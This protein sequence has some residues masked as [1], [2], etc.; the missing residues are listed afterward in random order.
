MLNQQDYFDKHLLRLDKEL[1]QLTRKLWIPVQLQKPIQQ[2]WRRVHVLAPRAD[3]RA[4][5]EVLI[6]LREV[7]GTVQYR[8]SPEFRNK[9]GRGKRRRFVEIEQPLRELTQGEWNRQQ[10]P[11]EWKRY[12]RLE[13]KCHFRAWRDVLV[14][15]NPH[16]FELKVEPCWVTVIHDKDPVVER[17]IAQI[18]RWLTRHDAGHRMEWLKGDSSCRPI[19][20]RQKEFAK[21]ARR[22]MR[23]IVSFPSE[24]DLGVSAWRIQISLRGRNHGNGNKHRCRRWA[25]AWTVWHPPFHCM[26]DI[27]NQPTVLVL[28][29]NWQ[30]IHVKTPA[31]AFCM[32]A[33][34]SALGLDVQG[35]DCILPVSW[36]A[37]LKLPV[38]SYDQVV[39]T[40]RG[41]VRMP[42]VITATAFAK[43]PLCRPRFGRRGIWERDGG[44][45]QYT[46]R[47]LARNEGN[48]DHVIPRSRGGGSTWE[49]C[50]LSHKE[51][52]SR[53]SDRLPQEAGLK[54]RRQPVAPRAYP[55]GVMIRNELKV[56]D[57]EYF[58]QKAG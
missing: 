14:F 56:R 9:R 49:N 29:R 55:A 11:E 54:L 26:K 32:M 19:P 7:I 46:G 18:K 30:A 48:I 42:T 6:A 34:G 44:I 50:V 43:V 53:K 36:E 20:R 16:V 47:K 17:H 5:K 2:G 35:D 40:P 51:V 52:N 57:W 33:S 8:K 25:L 31:E 58:L 13:S 22:E 38:R 24:V 37:W 10:L 4:D 45:C 15:T 21:I 3:R 28:N 1:R 41:R 39:N 27:L 12:F 23:E